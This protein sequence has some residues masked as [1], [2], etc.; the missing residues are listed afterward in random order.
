MKSA[1]ERQKLY[2]ERQRFGLMPARTWLPIAVVEYFVDIGAITAEQAE[3]PDELGSAV[4]TWAIG[5]AEEVRGRK[6]A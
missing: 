3:N 2:R 5:Q 1:A 4:A 6:F